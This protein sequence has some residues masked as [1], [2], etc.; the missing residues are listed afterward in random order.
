MLA[1][2][3]VDIVRIEHLHTGTPVFGTFL[4]AMPRKMSRRGRKNHRMTKTP[5]ILLGM[6]LVYK[7]FNSWVDWITTHGKI[8]QIVKWGGRDPFPAPTYEGMR[9]GTLKDCCP[10]VLRICRVFHDFHQ[11][12]LLVLFAPHLLSFQLI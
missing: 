12:H 6:I 11:N 1:L 4:I 9:T 10:R 2:L 7:Q 5:R 8:A 3:E